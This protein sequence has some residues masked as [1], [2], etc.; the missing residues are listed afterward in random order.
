LAAA[1]HQQ[2]G[3]EKATNNNNNNNNLLLNNSI[4][5]DEPPRAKSVQDNVNTYEGGDRNNDFDDSLESLMAWETHRDPSDEED[6]QNQNSLA[7]AEHK[8][9]QSSPKN[10]SMV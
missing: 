3:A 8:I 2:E 6:E 9:N 5:I 1:D 10:T 4:L 7:S